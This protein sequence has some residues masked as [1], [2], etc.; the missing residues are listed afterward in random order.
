M[1]TLLFANNAQT[2]LAGPIASGALTV[3]VAGGT[4]SEFPTVGTGQYFVMTLTDAAT[5][6]LHEIVF[7]TARSGDT[8]TIVRAQEGTTA[9]SWLAG[10]IAG[11]W[12]TAGSAATMVQV[13]A[14]QVQAGNYAVDTG[15]ANN[16]QIALNPTPAT[17]ATI[18]GAPIR[19]LVKV[20][21]SGATTLTIAGLASTVVFPQSGSTFPAGAIL[22][23]QI[24]EFIYV[25]GL[26]FE[27]STA[28][29]L[30][31]TLN[32]WALTQA[33]SNNAWWAGQN[34]SGATQF[35]LGVDTNNQTTMFAGP[36]GSTAFRISN[37]AITTNLFTVGT[38]G[39]T[40]AAG[41]LRAGTGAFNSG[42]PNTATLLEDFTRSTGGSPANSYINERLPDGTIIQSYIGTTVTGADFVTFPNPFPTTCVEVVACE[43]APSGW[44]V[45]GVLAPTIF[46]TQQLSSTSFAVYAARWVSPNWVLSGGITYRYI[47]IGY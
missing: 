6:L 20:T 10:D 43:G 38:D 22:G 14:L 13:Q 16:I 3:N 30:L 35:L 36:S 40:L 33:M 41:R 11:N 42:D 2:T 26:G 19:V 27:V 18:A 12:W 34:T 39:T 15:S 23:G 37:N 25:P 5:G 9:L 31:S 7:V 29:V 1:S 32:A 47:A 45:G 8:L 44:T 24:Y 21:N 46:G 4:G 28:R 17:L